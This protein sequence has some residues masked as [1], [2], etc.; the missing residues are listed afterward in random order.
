MSTLPPIVMVHGMWGQGSIWQNF[1]A[2]FEQAGYTVHTP[3]LRHHELGEPNKALGTTSL[4]DYVADLTS[5]ISTLDEKPILI[6]HSMGGLL[7]QK[8]M[9]D[10]YGCAA[11]LLC[12]A[13]PRGVFPV[14]PRMLPT[15]SRVMMRPLF[16]NKPMK[17]SYREARYGLFN[18]MS[19]VDAED[20]YEQMVYESGRA[21]AEIAFATVR[22]SGAATIDFSSNNRPILCLAGNQDRTIPASVCQKNAER[23]G[24]LSTYKEY[25]NHGHF[26]FAEPDWESIASDCLR[27]LTER[28]NPTLAPY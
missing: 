21:L 17:L 12:S 23:Y 2:P 24:T 27:W 25:P 20:S 13:P 8:L 6:G 9:A 19:K 5:F 7:V 16:W 18:M 10:G 26:I 14:R 1:K 3:T 4:N 28:L 11:I 22:P 15:L